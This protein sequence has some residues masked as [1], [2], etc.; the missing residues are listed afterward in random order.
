MFNDIQPF[1]M[2]PFPR[3]NPLCIFQMQA[4]LDIYRLE[5]KICMSEENFC[6]GA[7][8]KVLY[9]LYVFQVVKMQIARFALSM[10]KSISWHIGGSDE[11]ST[12][13]WKFLE[14]DAL[15]APAV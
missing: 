15:K 6:F 1:S 9:S 12:H 5:G 3:L 8:L 11:I 2:K 14:I 10:I 7:Y 13:G 4:V